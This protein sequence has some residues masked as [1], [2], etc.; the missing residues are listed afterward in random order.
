MPPGEL[1]L[2]T[3]DHKQVTNPPSPSSPVSF[4]GYSRSSASSGLYT[5]KTS[6]TPKSQLLRYLAQRLRFELGTKGYPES[7]HR[8]NNHNDLAG[9]RRNQPE[10]RIVSLA[11]LSRRL[12]RPNHRT[13]ASLSTYLTTS[14]EICVTITYVVLTQASSAPSTSSR[15][16]SRSWRTRQLTGQP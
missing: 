15:S 14:A 16:T 2:L 9:Q 13:G 1:P 11:R 12:A 5:V 10:Y 7:F 8:R 3:E 4:T 6:S